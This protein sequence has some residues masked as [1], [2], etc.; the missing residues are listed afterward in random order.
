MTYDDLNFADLTPAQQRLVIARYAKQPD[1]ESISTIRVLERLG[2]V[3]PN[4]YNLTPRAVRAYEYYLAWGQ[5]VKLVPPRLVKDGKVWCGTR[6][7]SR[8][9]LDKMERIQADARRSLMK[10]KGAL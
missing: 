5:D 1:N 3:E 4:T 2:W 9:F 6:R 7:I 8:T 10:S